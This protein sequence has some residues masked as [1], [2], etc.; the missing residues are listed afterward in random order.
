MTDEHAVPN[1]WNEQQSTRRREDG[2]LRPQ[3]N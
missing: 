3:T 2:G 1:T